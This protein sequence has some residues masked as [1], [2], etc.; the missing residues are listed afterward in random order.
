LA[1]LVESVPLEH[2]TAMKA[3]ATTTPDFATV[4]LSALFDD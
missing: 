2:A 1:A 3:H 4:L